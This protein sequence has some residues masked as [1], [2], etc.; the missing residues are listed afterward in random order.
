MD[1]HGLGDNN[2]NGRPAPKVEQPDGNWRFQLRPDTR[3]RI[4]E[5]I[6]DTLKKHLPFSHGGFNELQKIAVKFEEKIYTDSRSQ[7]DYL[8]KI[9]M[10]MMS[11]EKQSQTPTA[12]SSKAVPNKGPQDPASDC[13]QSQLHDE[14]QSFALPL[15]RNQM[16][17]SQ[18]LLPPNIVNNSSSA[19]VQNSVSLPA[20]IPPVTSN[21]NLIS[22]T[23]SQDSNL[24][25]IAGASENTLGSSMGQGMSSN[26]HAKSQRKLPGMQ[27]SQQAVP[28]HQQQQQ[29][30]QM[31]QQQS[32]HQ[33]LKKFQ[34]VNIPSSVLQSHMQQQKQE[35]EQ[36]Q[37]HQQ[38]NLLQS[39]QLQ[40]S[41]QPI[42]QT[43]SI[44]KPTT[45]QSSSIS[46]PKENPQ[47][48]YQQSMQS[49]IQR[50]PQS[51]NRQQQ[52]QPPQT[53]SY[54]QQTAMQQQPILATEQQQQLTGLQPNP[55]SMQQNQSLGQQ[56]GVPDVQMQHQQQR[57]PNPHNN[58]ASL[59]QQQL[60]SQKNN[61]SNMHQKQLGSKSNISGLQLQQEVLGT[62]SN[63][64]IQANQHSVRKLQSKVPVPQ[65]SQ[66]SA[67][68][69]MQS[70]GQQ[71]Q[72]QP[73]QQDLQSQ[74]QSQP[75]QLQ[76]Q[77]TNS[78]RQ[79]MQQ[80]IQTSGSLLQQQKV[81]DQQNELLQQQI[82]L[83]EASS[84]S[85]DSTSQTGSSCVNWLEDTY[86][87]IQAMKEMYLPELSEV[88]Q[89][90]AVRLQ[91][92]ESLPQPPKMDQ[93][94]RLKF[95]KG[96][97]ERMILFLQLPKN[98]IEP[99]HREK[100]D[101]F[102]KQI[103][104]FL[105]S[106]NRRRKPTSAFLQQGQQIHQSHVQ[107]VRQP[108]QPQ[109][110]TSQVL[111]HE[112]QMN[113][114][115]QVN[116][117]TDARC[118]SLST[119]SA[120]SAPQHTMMNSL[121]PTTLDSGKGGSLSSL[122]QN[123]A[124]DSPQARVNTIISQSAGNMLQSNVNQL[125]ANSGLLQQQHL[126]HQQERQLT[127][128]QQL[129]QLQQCQMQQQ[130]MQQK[131]NLI[132]HHLPQLHQQTKQQQSSQILQMQWVHQVNEVNDMRVRQMGSKVGAFPQ[133][134][135]A[136]RITTYHQQ[137]LKS[138]SLLPIS[139]PQLHQA[140]SPQIPQ[141]PS[142]QVDRP[143]LLSKD[144]T[145][146]QSSTSSF[147]VPSP[148]TPMAPSPALGDSEKLNTGVSSL[149]NAGNVGHRQTTCAPA[150]VPCP[151]ISTPAMS[152]SPLL[153]EFSPVDENHDKASKIVSGKSSISEQPVERL[154][155]VVKSISHEAFS[156]SVSDIGLL[157]GMFDRLAGSASGNGSRAAV[158]EDL[159]A[160]TN[161]RLQ[162]R[163]FVTQ[164]GSDGTIK[165]SCNT[166]GMPFNVGSSAGSVNDSF[167][168][169]RNSD[170]SDMMLSATYTIKRPRIEANRALL[171]EIRE[172]NQRLVDT[173]VDISNEGF[174]PTAAV[175]AY[176]A[177]EG[178][179]VKCSF[180]AVAVSPNVK[181]QHDSAQMSPIQPLHLLI[182]SNYPNC[183]PILLDKFSVEVSKEDKDRSVKAKSRFSR[184]LRSLLEPMSLGE[185]A[186][187][188]DV[189]A[190]AVISDY[191]EKS[192]GGSFSSRYGTWE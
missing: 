1:D 39:T 76:Q 173:V 186:R 172:I 75:R 7:S 79:D 89:K 92:H 135:S 100:L 91:Q 53:T 107:T 40:N 160:M 70:Q 54:Q 125:Q 98:S 171:E 151:I 118:D 87:K 165:L 64:S 46:S 14:R 59:Q 36:E 152:A 17:P 156:S 72:P 112:N 140:A 175:V 138:G 83:P 182:P 117:A 61:L 94:E 8:R 120:A 149:A 22:S 32:Q 78:L 122:Q 136:A 52:W 85:L 159:V 153:A 131:Q 109:S 170:T 65:Q 115:L 103:N 166:S 81:I 188:W 82:A 37:K 73:L 55:T 69:L 137:Q 10:K 145:P 104:H 143:N 147:V 177:G 13:M 181:S 23:T 34:Q 150:P 154:M 38:Q 97:T 96:I 19:G 50:H 9:S 174:D 31:Y 93:I 35:Q 167:K 95:F 11:M 88:R 179:T 44:L 128:S 124:S 119:M 62:Q 114:R 51:V 113:P 26:M 66:P 189:C 108:Q 185:M 129:K 155:K 191:A 144:G 142:P 86:Q 183:S 178:T 74:M 5:R 80:R 49:M 132:Q 56:S 192:G 71:P 164:A 127:Q 163:N 187:T 60:L 105:N 184:S 161:C 58:L 57:L 101:C 106:A 6:L 43:S 141:I 18:Q 77:I 168:Q 15:G 12:N 33:L 157:V 134:H 63:N 16:Q 27:H 130:M 47:T 121:Q 99:G 67:S 68:T 190:R 158:G 148:L 102:E 45:V 29:Q 84:T 25:N 110:Q 146:L 42:M 24:Q 169:L 20:S 139:S 176:E 90:I 41:Q 28:Q 133:H 2:N 180:S 48:A 30:S 21:P 111:S 3:Q 4:V 162:A 123:L 126:K 116:K